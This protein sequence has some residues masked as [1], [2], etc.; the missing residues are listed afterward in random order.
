MPRYA[1]ILERSFQTAWRYKWLWVFASLAALGSGGGSSNS[2]SNISNLFD[3]KKNEDN[4]V[5]FLFNIKDSP[6]D[7]FSQV[8]SAT[9]NSFE[10]LLSSITPLHWTILGIALLITFV[11]AMII[12]FIAQRFAL[13]AIISG[14]NQ[15]LHNQEEKVSELAQSGL[16]SLKTMVNLAVIQGIIGIFSFFIPIIIWLLVFIFVRDTI[17]FGLWIVIGFL[18]ALIMLFFVFIVFGITGVY[19]ERLV[20]L[21]GMK[22]KEAWLSAFKL[23]RK[24]L[25][26]SLVMGVINGTVGCFATLIVAL[27]TLL[28][29]GLSIWQAVSEKSVAWGIFGG[30]LG[31]IMVFIF[32]VLKAYLYT[33]NTANWNQ[34]FDEF[35]KGAENE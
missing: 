27:V 25:W 12:G 2:G 29:F 4:A 13:G 23:A 14:T 26:P 32:T 31:L 19:A 20:V 15:A 3:E 16:K 6:Q 28:P 35:M 21:K 8:L 34:L 11:A 9:T 5:S 33:V 17:L 7:S 30:L 18:T 22:S 10:S 1:D 24:K